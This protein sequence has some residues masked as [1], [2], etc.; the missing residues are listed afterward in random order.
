MLKP[1]YLRSFEREIEKS[2]KRG[3]DMTKI[4]E[5]MQDLIHEK[6][7]AVKR[8]ASPRLKDLGAVRREVA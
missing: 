4:K 2:Q 7:L 3:L 1:V 8:E 5:I 6:K